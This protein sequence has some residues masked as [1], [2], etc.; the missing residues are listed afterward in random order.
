[1]VETFVSRLPI[2]RLPA[3]GTW[4]GEKNDRLNSGEFVVRQ[5]RAD[6]FADAD[7]TLTLE[8]SENGSAWSTKATLPVTGGQTAQMA[9]QALTKHFYRFSYTNGVGAQ[10]A[11]AL[12]LVEASTT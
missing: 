5:I 9:Y 8:E 12:I 3:G 6:V 11:P 7:G 4:S 1:M 10:T 2:H